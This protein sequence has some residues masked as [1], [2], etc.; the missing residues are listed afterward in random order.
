MMTPNG[1]VI[2]GLAW[3]H[4]L[5]TAK[6]VSLHGKQLKQAGKA[7][8]VMDEEKEDEEERER[9]REKLVRQSMLSSSVRF[10]PSLDG[11]CDVCVNIFELAVC[12]CPCL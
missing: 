1:S 7:P 4:S 11:C 3:Q 12:P 5:P 8:S 6:H 10:L 2:M 9:E